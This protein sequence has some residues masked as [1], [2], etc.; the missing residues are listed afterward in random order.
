MKEFLGCI[1]LK[2][3]VMDFAF[4]FIFYVYCISTILCLCDKTRT[5]CSNEKLEMI[6]DKI[7]IQKSKISGDFNCI[8]QTDRNN[9]NKTR[10]S[11]AI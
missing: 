6:S 7:F 4:L 5:F 11:K 9:Y 2:L 1:T 10:S 8:K 3:M